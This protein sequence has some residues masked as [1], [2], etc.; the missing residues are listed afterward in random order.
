M[1][2][3]HVVEIVP[4]HASGDGR[5]CVVREYAD[6]CGLECELVCGGGAWRGPD[7]GASFVGERAAL[8]AAHGDSGLHLNRQ[9]VL[10]SGDTEDT[11]QS[12]LPVPLPPPH[13][14]QRPGTTRDPGLRTPPPAPSP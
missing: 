6:S 9:Q 12:V 10:M 1:F 11:S 4:I 14:I 8:H 7:G 5:P 3:S 2:H 13:L